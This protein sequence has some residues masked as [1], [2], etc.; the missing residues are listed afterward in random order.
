MCNDL[1]F[2][3]T[4]LLRHALFLFIPHAEVL[5]N[6]GHQGCKSHSLSYKTALTELN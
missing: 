3:A 2:R 1:A 4:R 5:L 6:G